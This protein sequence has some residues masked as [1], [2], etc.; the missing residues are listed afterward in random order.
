MTWF[1]ARILCRTGTQGTNTEL[2]FVCRVT[3]WCVSLSPR[4][5]IGQISSVQFRICKNLLVVLSVEL[6]RAGRFFSTHRYVRTCAH[7]MARGALMLIRTLLNH[8]SSQF[9]YHPRTFGFRKT[10]ASP[11]SPNHFYFVVVSCSVRGILIPASH[12]Y[13]FS[14]LIHEKFKLAVKTFPHSKFRHTCVKGMFRRYS[15]SR[16]GEY[17]PMTRDSLLMCTAALYLNCLD[18]RD[19]ARLK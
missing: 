2:K 19:A 13:R 3:G 11:T 17:S 1:T 8:P 10:S 15:S 7:T 18:L 4:L 16:S 5:P 6:P 14:C 9:R 12:C